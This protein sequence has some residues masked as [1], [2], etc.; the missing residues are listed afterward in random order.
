MTLDDCAKEF[1]F[2]KELAALSPATVKDY[3]CYIHVFFKYID[4]NLPLDSVSLE[5]VSDSLR[6]LLR[7]HYSKATIS[8]YINN[9]RIFLRWIHKKYHLPFDP[10]EITVPKPPKKVV[11]IL[12]D[13]EVQIL[14]NSVQTSSEW[15]TARDRAIVAFLLDSG[16]RLNEI[17][18]LLKRNIDSERMIAKIT[19]KGAKDRFIPLGHV[20]FQLIQDYLALC[21]Y[22][23]SDYVFL[24]RFGSPISRNTI[25]VFMNHLKHK[26][27]LDISC[28][29][30]R[31]NFATNFCIDSLRATGSTNIPDLSVLM[32]HESSETTKRYEHYARDIVAAECHSS[33]LD[34][35]F[36]NKNAES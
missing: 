34:R 4:K 17:C 9:I 12:N 10:K 5:V 1:I 32:G 13:S 25:K 20:V 29:K 21:P 36:L 7:G 30:L 18:G 24:G 14:L 27:G 22:K 33:H 11:R 3:K 31:H 28:H 15:I 2:Q 23:N 16:L 6:R 26:T 35:V 8:T 19:G